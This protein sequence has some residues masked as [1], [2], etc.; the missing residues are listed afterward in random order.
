MSHSKDTLNTKGLI[1][2]IDKVIK[3]Y[4][5]SQKT[6][7]RQSD[8]LKFLKEEIQQIKSENKILHDRLKSSMFAMAL[9]NHNGD[10]EAIAKINRLVRE[11]D[12]CIALLNK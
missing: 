4:E 9:K 1:E 8:E 11:I 12:S 7:E 2:K 5:N 10:T 3:L 6:V